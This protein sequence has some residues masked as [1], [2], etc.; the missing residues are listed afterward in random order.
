MINENVLKGWHLNDGVSADF[1][2]SI[3][4]T[5][6]CSLPCDYLEFIGRHNGGEGFLGGNYLI[7]WRIEELKIFNC[8][9][10]VSKYAP[11]ILLFGSDGGGEA[12]GFDT[13]DK[14]MSIVRVPFVGMCIDY[15]IKVSDD[16]CGLFVELRK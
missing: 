7:L 6:G 15:V 5:I 9:Y 8:E 10:E 13:R 3:A 14:R 16:F 1:V 12:Y 2:R 11:G 4:M